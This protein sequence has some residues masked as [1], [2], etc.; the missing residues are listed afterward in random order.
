MITHLL[1]SIRLR[2]ALLMI[3][4]ID[5][6]IYCWHAQD[7]YILQE[8]IRLIF[9]RGEIIISCIIQIIK[10]TQTLPADRRKQE[11]VELRLKRSP[12]DFSATKFYNLREKKAVCMYF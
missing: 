12:R 4:S 6:N 5:L 1:G 8:E 11:Q 2:G 10:G 7:N 3:S 9:I